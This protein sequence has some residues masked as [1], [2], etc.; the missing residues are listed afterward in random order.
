[1]SLGAPGPR[2]AATALHARLNYHHSSGLQAIY[3]PFTPP[4]KL[5][6]HTQLDAHGGVVSEICRISEQMREIALAQRNV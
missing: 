2:L 5:L 3:L 4:E 1:M 6:A